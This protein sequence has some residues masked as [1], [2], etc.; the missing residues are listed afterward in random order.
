VFVVAK[1]KHIKYTISEAKVDIC[2]SVS[3]NA[4]AWLLFLSSPKPIAGESQIGV[5][6]FGS[7][8]AAN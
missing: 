2:N 7:D 8:S 6:F 1:V 3:Q 4:L 5:C